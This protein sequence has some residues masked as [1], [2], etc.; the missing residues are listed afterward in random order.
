[1]TNEQTVYNLIK[2]GNALILKKTLSDDII[3]T[4]IALHMARSTDLDALG[5]QGHLTPDSI[6]A[7]E[8]LPCLIETY[9]ALLWVFDRLGIN[10]SIYG[11][12]FKMTSNIQASIH[13]PG[14]NL[15]TGVI[16]GTNT[17]NLL[18]Q[19]VAIMAYKVGK[20]FVADN[21]AD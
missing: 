18:A 10:K 13:V 2:T 6:H 14:A 3:A 1:M 7:Q 16:E 21:L 15:G 12:P 4:G 5:D 8:G 19:E 9:T 11:L 20:K 17:Q